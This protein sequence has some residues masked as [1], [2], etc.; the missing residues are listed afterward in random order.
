MEE[1]PLQRGQTGSRII[2]GQ[3]RWLDFDYCVAILAAAACVVIV[4]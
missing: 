1:V 3:K 4:R 2:V